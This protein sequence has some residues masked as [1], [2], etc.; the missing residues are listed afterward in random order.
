M[1]SRERAAPPAAAACE[2]TSASS[3]YQRVVS[4][5]AR[6]ASTPTFRGIQGGGVRLWGAITGTRCPSSCCCLRVDSL[7]RISAIFL[8]K[9]EPGWCVVLFFIKKRN[10][11][12]LPVETNQ[13]VRFFNRQANTHI[14]ER[15]S[16]YEARVF[17]RLW[18][19][20]K[21]F[22]GGE[23]GLGF[24][25]HQPSRKD[26]VDQFVEPFPPCSG[27]SGKVNPRS[28]NGRFGRSVRVPL[29]ARK[30]VIVNVGF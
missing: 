13:L 11:P 20:V 25:G 6:P 9:T 4:K 18:K 24:G 27:G 30:A 29:E 19:W 8:L 28:E 5:P 2:Q 1:P 14:Q 15:A 12:K 23:T 21:W 3:A 10:C 22:E 26:Q 7:L 16:G 17:V